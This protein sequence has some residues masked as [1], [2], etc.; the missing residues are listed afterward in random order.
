[1]LV[2]SPAVIL[3]N[4]AAA[5]ALMGIHV[6]VHIVT[7][8]VEL[9]ASFGKALPV[10]EGRGYLSPQDMPAARSV[11]RAAAYT[12]VAA[13]LATLLNVARWF[14]IIRI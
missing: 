1:M 14:R 6:V 11:L 3:L 4:I 8:P 2:K 12:Y 9:D 10:L 7:L 13:A 5:I